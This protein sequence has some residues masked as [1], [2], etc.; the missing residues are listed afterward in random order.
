[1][2]SPV[3]R[4]LPLTESRSVGS[5]TPSPTLPV[6]SMNISACDDSPWSSA[7]GCTDAM[8][9]PIPELSSRTA[10]IVAGV[11]PSAEPAGVRLTVDEL[12]WG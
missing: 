3:A 5:A 10:V 8:V 1:M 11:A 4:M 2:I 9:R 12:A 6:E 7:E